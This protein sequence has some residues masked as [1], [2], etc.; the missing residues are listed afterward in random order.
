MVDTE[1]DAAQPPGL[2]H[3]WKHDCVCNKKVIPPSCSKSCGNDL[4]GSCH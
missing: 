1:V 3:A 2:G 4:L